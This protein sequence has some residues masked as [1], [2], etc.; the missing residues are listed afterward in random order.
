MR[1][2]ILICGWVLC[3]QYMEIHKVVLVKF[4]CMFSV[5]MSLNLRNHWSKHIHNK[6][7]FSSST[8]SKYG[9]PLTLNGGKCTAALLFRSNFSL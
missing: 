4:E 3:F 1:K 6:S 9:E 7:E 8:R 2:Q 5:R